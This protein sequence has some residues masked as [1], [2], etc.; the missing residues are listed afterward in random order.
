MVWYS[1]VLYGLV[2]HKKPPHGTVP[3]CIAA[4]TIEPPLSL[5]PPHLPNVLHTR[6]C[7]PPPYRTILFHTTPNVLHTRPGTPSYLTKPYHSIPHLPNVLHSRPCTIPFK[8]YL[9]IFHPAILYHTIQ[10]TPAH[11]ANTNLTNTLHKL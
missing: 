1:M 9:T 10:S 8:P 2:W 11:H 6:L 3:K 5:F 7:T 4:R